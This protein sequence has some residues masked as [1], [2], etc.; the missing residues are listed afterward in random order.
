MQQKGV[1]MM[2]NMLYKGW[3][4]VLVCLLLAGS[5]PLALAEQEAAWAGPESFNIYPEGDQA[6]FDQALME[7]RLALV[8]LDFSFSLK[9]AEVLAEINRYFDALA[10]ADPALDTRD[11]LLQKYPIGDTLDFALSDL[12]GAASYLSLSPDGRS[13]FVILE[14][15]PFVLGLEDGFLRLVAPETG[16]NPEYIRE[17]FPKALY[18]V[19]DGGVVWS[20][21]GS[22]LALANPRQVMVYAFPAINILL[23]DVQAGSF[24][25]VDPDVPHDLRLMVK[26]HQSGFPFRAGF[27][28]VEPVLY[29]EVFGIL[30]GKERVSEVRSL[31]LATGEDAPYARTQPEWTTS[32]PALWHT[33]E[34]LLQ[35]VVSIAPDG[36]RGLALMPP[37]A[38]TR[39]VA[40]DINE[41]SN[42]TIAQLQLPS[43][44]EG[45]GVL[46]A[47]RVG[48]A[49]MY[50]ETFQL[51]DIK[52]NQDG[53]FDSH[54]AV[55]PDREKDLRVAPLSLA[56][57]DMAGME[58]LYQDPGLML[59]ANAVLSPDGSHLALAGVYGEEARLYILDIQ[60]GIAGRV[61]L[62]AVGVSK[63]IS[64]A[65]F[66]RL[67]N[68]MAKGLVWS[69][70]NRLLVHSDGGY[71]LY[72][73]A[74]G[75]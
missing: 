31:N 23:V 26:G 65:P 8:P 22:H 48:K 40:L 12:Y 20:P 58:A 18:A 9:G 72:G 73:L 15:I 4:L 68:R 62:T 45:R 33:P 35:T 59:P 70:N 51:F 5:G 69:D 60:R 41:P 13:L 14:D 75:D 46:L 11:T 37:G 27:S 21:G 43:Y 2:K 7:D 36:K 24:R 42:R 39:Y 57:L 50:H 44:A 55:W 61:D 1:N 28:Q 63:A 6:A 17:V 71:R 49:G 25:L 54:L 64:F 3:L 66:A 56:G 10:Q 16:V 29:Y 30:E 19:Q 74:V 53:L 32:D 47:Y 67:T 34:G 52:N 38:D